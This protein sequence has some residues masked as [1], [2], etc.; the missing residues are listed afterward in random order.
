MCIRDRYKA[1]AV[2]RVYV[3]KDKNGRRPIGISTIED[4]VLQESVRRVLEPVYE[5]EFKPFSY[6]FRPGRSAHDA[7]DYMFK[8]VSV[9][10]KHYIIDADITDYF[11]SINHGILRGFL[12]KRIR[13]GVIRKMIDKWLKAGVMELGSISYSESGT[14]QGSLCEASHNDPY[15]K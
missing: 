10:K 15:A 3:P 7:I 13:D 1:P 14:P 9:R 6:G 4:K 2:R 5:E 11:G 12:D 8:E